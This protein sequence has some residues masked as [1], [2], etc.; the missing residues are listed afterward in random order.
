MTTDECTNSKIVCVLLT[1]VCMRVHAAGFLVTSTLVYLTLCAIPM[2][3]H[4]RKDNRTAILSARVATQD[5]SSDTTAEG[6]TAEDRVPNWRKVVQ[7]S[8]EAAGTV[9]KTTPAGQPTTAQK[10]RLMQALYDEMNHRG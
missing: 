1:I 5:Q 7:K 4:A 6:T 2:Q 8:G 10:Q 9:F 3:A